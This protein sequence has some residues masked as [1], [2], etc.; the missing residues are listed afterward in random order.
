MEQAA[1]PILILQL[2]KT[3]ARSNTYTYIMALLSSCN[4]GI[5]Q[6]W[7]RVQIAGRARGQGSPDHVIVFQATFTTLGGVDDIGAVHASSIPPLYLPT[8]ALRLL[9]S[10]VP[11]EAKWLQIKKKNLT[12]YSGHCNIRSTSL[13]TSRDRWE[14]QN[15]SGGV[16]DV[17]HLD[18]CSLAKVR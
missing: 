1:I 8:M 13:S 10:T 3:Q 2:Y 4:W 7:S 5:A 9:R 15:S 16:K 12:Q 11:C 17:M 18:C 6:L 14:Q